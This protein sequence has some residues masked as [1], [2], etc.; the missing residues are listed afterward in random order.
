[1]SS[2]ALS[3]STQRSNSRCLHPSSA[4]CFSWHMVRL[5][6]TLSACS[7]KQTKNWSRSQK[8]RKKTARDIHTRT[9]LVHCAHIY[10]AGSALLWTRQWDDTNH[11]EETCTGSRWTLECLNIINRWMGS[12]G[13]WAVF[14]RGSRDSDGEKAGRWMAVL[15]GA[16]A[17][18]HS[19]GEVLL[20]RLRKNCGW[21]WM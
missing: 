17:C 18:C 1:M 19:R 13:D 16:V 7:H 15:C 4:I 10:P 6:Q 11:K 3:A 14:L 2:K 20:T 21:N 9:H 5:I 8:R 12:C